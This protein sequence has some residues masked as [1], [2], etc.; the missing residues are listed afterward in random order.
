M[1][2]IDSIRGTALQV[3]QAALPKF[4]E[5][6]MKLDE[7]VISVFEQESSFLVVFDDPNR[8]SGQRGSSP[9]VIAFEVEIS[10]QGLQAIRSNFVR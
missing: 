9:G 4:E 5:Q 7:Y 10:K 3:V 2:L 1:E 8:P 6:G